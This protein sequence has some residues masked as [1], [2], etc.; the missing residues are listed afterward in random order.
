M[1]KEIEETFVA[2]TLYHGKHKRKEKD[3]ETPLEKIQVWDLYMF[4]DRKKDKESGNS[5]QQI[6]YFTFVKHCTSFYQM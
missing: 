2:D 3:D 5:Q 6:D 1:L 4:E